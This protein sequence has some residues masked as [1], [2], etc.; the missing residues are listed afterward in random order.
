MLSLLYDNITPAALEEK[1]EDIFLPTRR[2]PVYH[3]IKFVDSISHQ[4]A[5]SV[6]AQPKKKSKHGSDMQGRFD[7]VLVN[8]GRGRAVGIKGV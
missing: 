5:D 6:H 4:V 1:A 2:L 7:T 3:R 8:N